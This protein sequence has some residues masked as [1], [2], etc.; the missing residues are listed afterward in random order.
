MLHII[1][2]YLIASWSPNSKM[3]V[4]VGVGGGSTHL[5]NWCSQTPARCPTIQVHSNTVYQ[6]TEAEAPILWPPD[7]KSW[8]WKRPWCWER[9][10]TG[11]EGDD[12]G[13]DGW[14]VSLT[15]WT[16]IWVNS[17]I[18]WWTGRPGM[19]QSMGP[20]RVGQDW[21]TELKWIIQKLSLMNRVG[22]KAK[23]VYFW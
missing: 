9:L 16:W 1:L 17:G 18:W 15:Q 11:R 13:W 12:R 21:V 5:Q 3:C 6:E 7:E 19:L 22:G 14:L 8:L 4:G 10:K 20:Q 23:S 2:L